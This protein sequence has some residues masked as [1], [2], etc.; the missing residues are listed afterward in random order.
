MRIVATNRKAFRDYE[1][2]EKFEAGIV[3]VGT[4]VKSAREGRVSLKESYARIKDGEVLLVGM[5]IGEYPPAGK[6]QHEPQRV[7][8]LLLHR[9]EI[10][11]L[12][13]KVKE[14]GVTLIPLSA[15]FNNRGVMKVEMGLCRGR[16]QF[17]KRE[18]IKKREVKR[19]IASAKRDFIRKK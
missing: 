12:D 8:K 14:K 16:K 11:R 13:H 5:F 7:R 19:L 3:L 1:V 9:R 6:K 2:L 18:R 4:E 10:E 17:D 15:Y